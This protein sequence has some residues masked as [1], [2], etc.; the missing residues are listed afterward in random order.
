MKIMVPFADGFE[1]IEA[2]TNVDVLRRAEIDV[3]TV[4]LDKEIV[5]GA[6]NIEFLTDF[7]ISNVDITELEGIILPGGMPSAANLRDNL[8]IINIVQE[9]Y[10]NNKL[11][12]AICAAPIVLEKAGIIKN[13]KVTS[14]PGFESQLKSSV[15]KTDRVVIDNNIITGRGPGVALEFALAIVNYLKN[16]QIAYQIKKDMIAEF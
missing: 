12:A 4:S 15:Y 16:D 10:K 9:L 6:H 13:K 14:F 8:K 11:I 7:N 5:T 3:L 2:I 1:E